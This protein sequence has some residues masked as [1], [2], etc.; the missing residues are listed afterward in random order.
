MLSLFCLSGCIVTSAVG[1]AVDTVT[2]VG[3]VAVKTVGA[4]ADAAIPDKED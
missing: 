3:S 4:V 2:T 1:L